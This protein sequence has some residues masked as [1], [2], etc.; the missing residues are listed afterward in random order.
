VATIGE[1]HIDLEGRNFDGVKD[2]PDCVGRVLVT[3]DRRNSE[4]ERFLRLEDEY[5]VVAVT[6]GGEAERS[7][8]VVACLMRRSLTTSSR[9]SD[10]MSGASL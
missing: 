7:R 5:N 6:V 9:V 1:D 8:I 10:S 3:R 4:R 2:A